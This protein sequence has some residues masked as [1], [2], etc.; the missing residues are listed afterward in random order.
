M[1]LNID[2]SALSFNLQKAQTIAAEKKI[3]VMLKSFYEYIPVPSNV[4]ILSK[5]RQ[6][7]TC[8]SVNKAQSR[9]SAAVILNSHDVLY[10]TQKSIR[11][12]Y[13]P[14]DC[15]DNREGL[16]IE[17][18]IEIGIENH[19]QEIELIAMITSGCINDIAPSPDQI[20]EIW[21]KIKHY[22]SGISVGGSYY[23]QRAEDLPDCVKEIRIGEYYLSGTIPYYNGSDLLGKNALQVEV[24][25]LH[26]YP[27]RKHILTEGGYET[28]DMQ[29]CGY[30]SGLKLVHTSSDY[31]V[32]E[33]NGG[34]YKA[35][36][37]LLVIPDYH[38]LVKLQYVERH[39]KE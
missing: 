18:V 31:S 34:K 1:I 11:K 25:V 24:K 3:A 4:S 16:S 17:K 15:G 28:I 19:C 9:H 21:E 29:R 30:P 7:S 38:S 6:E 26:G 27:E 39:Y 33:D 20:S 2:K 12:F 5:S 22:Y 32:F 14:A 36:D 10:L 35:G 13:V 8:Y 37:V 23:L